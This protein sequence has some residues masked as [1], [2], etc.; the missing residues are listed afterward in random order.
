MTDAQTNL[1]LAPMAIHNAAAVLSIRLLSDGGRVALGA[2]VEGPGGSNLIQVI[3][4]ANPGEYLALPPLESPFGWP[5]WDISGPAMGALAAVWTKPGSAL[6]PL[7]YRSPAGKDIVLTGR[8]PAGIFQKPRFLRSSLNSAPAVTALAF[9]TTGRVLVLFSGSLESGNAPYIPL[10]P[11]GSGLIEDGLLLGDREGFYLLAKL[12]VPAA[13]KPDRAGRIPER[14]YGGETPQP[15]V[16]YCS[17][18]N[19]EFQPEGVPF[20][21]FGDTPIFEVDAELSGDRLFVLATTEKGY[22]AGAAGP[23]EVYFLRSMTSEV[24]VPAELVSP[25]LL[26]VKGA[27]YSAVIESPGKPHAQILI[28]HF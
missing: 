16:L 6:C 19:E 26:G 9:Q 4:L 2:L 24:A 14:K 1:K 12:R 3:P 11:A 18:L 20:Q 27:V 25:V 8:Y 22:I 5:S 15:G 13:L 10:P 23:K 21:P 17:R 7:G 28:G